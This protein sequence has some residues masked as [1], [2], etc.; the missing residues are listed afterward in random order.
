MQSLEFDRFLDLTGL[1]CPIPVVKSR[2]EIARMVTG[3]TLKVTATDRGSLK[4]FQG[5]AH[6][7]KNIILVAQAIDNSEGRVVYTHFIRKVA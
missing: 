4:N 2:E 5:W 7:A 1:E 6:A 3:E